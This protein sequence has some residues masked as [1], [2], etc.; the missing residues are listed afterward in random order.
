MQTFYSN[1]IIFLSNVL[2]QYIKNIPSNQ[3]LFFILKKKSP[4]FE[5][6]HSLM[7]YLMYRWA[8]L[9][10]FARSKGLL[11][12]MS[13]VHIIADYMWL[14]K[15]RT[16]IGIGLILKWSPLHVWK[17]SIFLW[18]VIGWTLWER[19][20]H[21]YSWWVSICANASCMQNQQDAKWG[22]P[23]VKWRILKE[24]LCQLWK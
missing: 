5:N 18:F 4:L 15:T 1:E 14:H 8:F 23:W 2:W 6:L 3:Y 16:H 7:M 10:L 24:H 11:C 22:H 9:S 12:L 21:I 17:V 20:N 13:S 19:V